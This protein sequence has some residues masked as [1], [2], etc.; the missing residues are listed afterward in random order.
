MGPSGSGKTTLLRCVSGLLMITTGRVNSVGLDMSA[1]SA[2]QRTRARRERIGMMFQDPELLPE[3]SLVENVA[4]TEIFDRAPRAR[5]LKDARNLLDEVGLADRADDRVE[6][7][8][9]GQAQRVALARALAR[10]QMSLLVADEPTASLDAATGRHVIDLTV[11]CVRRLHA[12]A[13]IAT[14]DEGVADR[15]DEVLVLGSGVGT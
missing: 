7:I 14:H 13:L 5:A 12:S 3:L 8:S 6:R 10:T 1:A 9:R 15:C 2:A 11:A 4:V